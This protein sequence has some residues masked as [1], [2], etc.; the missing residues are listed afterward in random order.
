MAAPFSSTGTA[1]SVQVRAISN[2]AIAISRTPTPPPRRALSP[3]ALTNYSTLREIQD[4][5]DKI[6]ALIAESEVQDP[7]ISGAFSSL[8]ITISLLHSKYGL[9]DRISQ[10]DMAVLM[11]ALG[12]I[13]KALENYWTS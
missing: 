10:Q 7:G 2:S 13:S 4:Y 9:D 6:Y 5:Y 12:R 3:R 8:K 11:R 1:A